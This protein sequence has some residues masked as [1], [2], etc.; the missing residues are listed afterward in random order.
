MDPKASNYVAPGGTQYPG[1][2]AYASTVPATVSSKKETLVTVS[3]VCFKFGKNVVPASTAV[4]VTSMQFFNVG[5][6]PKQMQLVGTT[7]Y[8]ISLGP[9]DTTIPTKDVEMCIDLSPVSA[10]VSPAGL[11]IWYSPDGRS[12]TWTKAMHTHFDKKTTTIYGT[13]QHFSYFGVFKT[14]QPSSVDSG[15]VAAGVLV[16]IIVISIAAFIGYRKKNNLPLLPS[17]CQTGSMF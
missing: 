5:F 9:D 15:A 6:D 3:D 12:D 8:Q 10:T 1:P 14:K 11:D 4:A 2:C 13:V 16:P 7:V 17:K